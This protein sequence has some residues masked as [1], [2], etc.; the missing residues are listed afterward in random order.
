MQPE[1]SDFPGLLWKHTVLNL[2]LT[3]S[4][5]ELETE[6]HEGIRVSHLPGHRLSLSVLLS[7]QSHLLS[8]DATA[9]HCGSDLVSAKMFLISTDFIFIFIFQTGS[10]RLASC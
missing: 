6:V 4:V 7:N 2:C 3:G 10:P 5:T 8:A 1:G 9:Q